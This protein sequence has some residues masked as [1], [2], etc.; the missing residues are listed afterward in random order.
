[1]VFMAVRTVCPVLLFPVIFLQSILTG[2]VVPNQQNTQ[3][4]IARQFIKCDKCV[5]QRGRE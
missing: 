2:Y 4:E 5:R 3:V 1:M